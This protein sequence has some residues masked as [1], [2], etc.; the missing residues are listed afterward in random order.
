MFD[1]NKFKAAIVAAGKTAKDVAAVL[2]VNESTFYRK[3][4]NNGAFSREEIQKMND[5]LNIENPH[6]I[7]F[8][9]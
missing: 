2:G 3:I 4:A 9:D 8:A 6:D 1:K 5:Y 7:F